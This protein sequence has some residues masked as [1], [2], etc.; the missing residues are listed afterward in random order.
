MSGIR[1]VAAIVVRAVNS[2]NRA[3]VSRAVVSV[4]GATIEYILHDKLRYQLLLPVVRCSYDD[5]EPDD[6]MNRVPR[7]TRL[8]AVF[9]RI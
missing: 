2:C 8:Q 1:N 7:I 9:H 4:E 3:T 6:A 5:D